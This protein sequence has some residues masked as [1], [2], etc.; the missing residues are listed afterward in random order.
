MA[1]ADKKSPGWAGGF[2]PEITVGLRER[3]AA[4][5]DAHGSVDATPE[6]NNAD[7]TG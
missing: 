5:R 6:A 1:G 3:L 4:A 2:G 7:R